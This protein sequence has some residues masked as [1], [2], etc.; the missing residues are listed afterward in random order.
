MNFLNRSTAVIATV[1]VVE[2]LLVQ[3]IYR[4]LT[5]DQ[6][7]FRACSDITGVG[8]PNDFI[9]FSGT[10]IFYDDEG[11]HMNGSFVILWDVKGTD[12]V[13][14][15]VELKKFVRGGWQPTPLVVRSEDVCKDQ[16]NI[17]SYVYEVWSQYV[18]PEDLQCF[19]EGITYRHKPFVLKA[20]ANAMVP[21]EGRY[22]VIFTLRAF[23]ENDTP[24]SKCLLIKCLLV[25]LTWP[26][27][28]LISSLNSLSTQHDHIM[29]PEHKSTGLPPLKTQDI[30]RPH[31]NFL[32]RYLQ[33]V[34]P[35]ISWLKAKS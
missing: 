1:I 11:I 24:K 23:D 13:S 15:L 16:K 10:D 9:D 20:E 29:P 21:M 35:Q 8:G 17:R 31:S 33:T 3:A 5:E 26:A 4:F 30:E 6:D 19:E 27:F 2:T 32:P 14:L 22:K 34:T 7:I 25:L 18:F 12:R 28:V